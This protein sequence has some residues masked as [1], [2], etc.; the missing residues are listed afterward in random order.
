MNN[1]TSPQSNPYVIL[2]TMGEKWDECDNLKSTVPEP[3]L[4]N[5]MSQIS[6]FLETG[7]ET[8]FKF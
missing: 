5:V 6:Q 7:K 4:L 8:I 3:E 1:V 2:E